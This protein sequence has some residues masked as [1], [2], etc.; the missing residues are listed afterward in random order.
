MD[1]LERSLNWLT[2]M[3][4]GWWPFLRLRPAKHEP[5][6]TARVA[7]MSLSFGMFYG[8]AVGVIMAGRGRLPWTNVPVIPF[9]LAA[10]FFVGYRFTFAVAWN[11]RAERLAKSKA[12]A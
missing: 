3:D 7:L 11:A 6:T 8:I 4:W 10:F 12:T 9:T 5:L 2:D 1:S